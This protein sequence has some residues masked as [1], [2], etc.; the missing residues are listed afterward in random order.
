[1]TGVAGHIGSHAEFP[2]RDAALPVAVIDNLTIGLRFAMPRGVQL[3]ESDIEDAGL[4]VRA[5]VEQNIRAN[6]QLAGAI[7][8]LE[9]GAGPLRHYHKYIA[10]SRA[11]IEAAVKAGL[12]LFVFPSTLATRGIL[13]DVATPRLPFLFIALPLT[14][15]ERQFCLSR[16][17]L[18]CLSANSS[19]RARG[20]PCFSLFCRELGAKCL[21]GGQKCHSHICFNNTICPI[22]CP[23][24]AG[25]CSSLAGSRGGPHRRGL[26]AG[27]IM[28]YQFR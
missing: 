21:L 4:P 22:P 11:W 16:Y 20:I 25:N 9:S 5:F 26:P 23:R 3:H 7:A 2:L 17:R 28:G 1:V 12:P 14:L 19:Y 27:P 13:H 6:M 15:L 18:R 8:V 10:Q 24:R